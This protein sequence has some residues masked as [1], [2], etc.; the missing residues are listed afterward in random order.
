M[1]DLLDTYSKQEH[2]LEEFNR[3][4]EMPQTGPTQLLRKPKQAQRRLQP[5]EIFDLVAAYKDGATITEL[6]KQFR[7]HAITVTTHL[8]RQGVK[9]RRRGLSQARIEEAARLYAEGWSLTKIGNRFGVYP[10][11]VRYRLRQ[12]GVQLRPR[13]GWD[14]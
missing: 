12:A 8:Q 14:K 2:W 4:L 9:L 10:H 1:V 5:D 3:I 6:A 13:P 11:S 7:I